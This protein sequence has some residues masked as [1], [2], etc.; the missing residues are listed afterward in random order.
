MTITAMDVLEKCPYREVCKNKKCGSDEVSGE[1]IKS[2]L[3]LTCE[4]HGVLVVYADILKIADRP[5]GQHRAGADAADKIDSNHDKYLQ[6]DKG[7]AALKRYRESDKGKAARQRHE[8]TDKSKL[9][10][11]KYYRSEKGQMAHN[12]YKDR[13]KLLTRIKNW[14]DENPGK[15]STDY[16]KEFPD[17]LKIME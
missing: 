7:K 5:E 12:K 16:F 3:G 2:E 13:Q 11:A 8:E 15:T 4:N 10:K 9:T 1:F 6:T 17:D 14:I